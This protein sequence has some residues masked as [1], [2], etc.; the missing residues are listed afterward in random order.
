M[1]ITE[2]LEHLLYLDRDF[3]SSYFEC[4]SGEAATTHFT[5]QE[6]KKVGAQIPLF[7]TEISAVEIKSYSVSSLR[8]LEES[9]SMLEKYAVFSDANNMTKSQYSWVQGKLS[10]AVSCQSACKTIQG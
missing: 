5:R 1:T 8:M 6:G 4:T 10:A 9:L 2:L 3:I 7:S